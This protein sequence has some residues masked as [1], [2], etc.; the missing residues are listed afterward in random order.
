[1]PLKGSAAFMNHSISFKLIF[2]DSEEG[3]NSLSIHFLAAST[4]AKL[5]R[6]DREGQGCCGHQILQLHDGS[7]ICGI[8]SATPAQ[9]IK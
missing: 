9:T 3:W 5:A 8:V 1:M 6:R 2:F 4:S 7:S